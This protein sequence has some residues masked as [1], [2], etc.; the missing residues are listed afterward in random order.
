M[1]PDLIANNI[2]N[3][4]DQACISPPKPSSLVK[5]FANQNYLD[6]TQDT[7]YKRKIINFAPNFKEFRE[8]TKKQMK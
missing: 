1:C 4:K 5:M 7:G 6:G 3:M 2:N 8:D